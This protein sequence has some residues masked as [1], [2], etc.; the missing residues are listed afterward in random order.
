MTIT[1]KLFLFGLA[2]AALTGWATAQA[3]PA[4]AAGDPAASI[5][6][7]NSGKRPIV[8]VYT[9]APG[10]SDWG[11]D[12][13]GKGTLKAGQSLSLKFKAKPSACKIDLSA[14]LD[15]G[16]TRTQSDIDVCSPR[17]TVAF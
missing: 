9:S 11:D 6:V 3:Q 7:A 14:L 2:W 5:Q 8:A 10:R 4:P 15:N 13:L 1:S 12:M 17:P 16:D